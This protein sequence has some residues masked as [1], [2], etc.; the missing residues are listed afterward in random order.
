MNSITP[1][2]RSTVGKKI[3]M[4]L[5][6]AALFLFVI[7]HLLGNL[8]IFLGPEALNRYGHFLQSN[9]ELV[10]PARLGLLA[11]VV[12]HIVAAVQLSA[13]NKA[14]RPVG[15]EGNPHP[16]ATTY[17]SRTML[18]SGLIIA[19]FIIYHLLHFTVLV[20]G[21]NF[22]GQ[23]F[24]AFQDEKGRHDIYRMMI[25]G[26]QQPIVTIFYLV[27]MALLCLHLSHG[28]YAMFQSLGLKP[29]CCPGFPRALAKWGS[30]LIFCG[31][32]AIPLAIL[33]GYGREYVTAPPPDPTVGKEMK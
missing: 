8:Q 14:A 7:A 11:C 12:L 28:I 24:A 10:W 5:T 4:A 20:K 1:M 27:A 23:D 33:S 26:F 13:A 16:V 32:A 2:W 31:Y 6:G 15:Y 30:I 18:M 29:G 21:L 9:M 25:L 17:A 19:A 3:V 22:S